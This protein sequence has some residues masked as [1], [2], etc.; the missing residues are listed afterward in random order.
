[1]SETT[2]NGADK[3]LNGDSASRGYLEAKGI[4]SWAYTLDHKR[5][6]VMY[7]Y[8][9]LFFFLL[10]GVFAFDFA[11]PLQRYQ[12]PS[13]FRFLPH[14]VQVDRS[15]HYFANTLNSCHNASVRRI[16]V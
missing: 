1:M 8:T 5:I 16:G 4:R 12:L 13:G 9:T 3:T 15:R 14:I 6:G 7:L 10:G 11:P 2:W